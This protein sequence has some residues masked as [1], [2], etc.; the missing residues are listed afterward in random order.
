MD[1]KYFGGKIV[2]ENLIASNSEDEFGDIDE[3]SEAENININEGVVKKNK[4]I[5]GIG[6]S[7][8][9]FNCDPEIKEISD[10]LNS[11]SI[12]DKLPATDSDEFKNLQKK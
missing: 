5:S 7:N 8:I 2:K 12:P 4:I 11:L 6:K 10:T 1:K 9:E 3:S